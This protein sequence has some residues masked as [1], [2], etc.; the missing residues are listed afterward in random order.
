MKKNRVRKALLA[1]ICLIALFFA[2]DLVFPFKPNIHYATQIT[3]RE[4]R[5]IHAFLSREDKWRLYSN[6]DEIT[7]LLR[8]TL[9]YKEDQYFY[10]HPG[11]NP[12]AVVR[13]A[14]RNVFSGKRTSGASTITMQVVRL[15][16]PRPRTY[17]NKFIEMWHA[18][19]LEMHYS[20]AEIL[21]FYINL[22]PYGGNIEGIKAASLLYFGK[23]P[24][25]LSL[26]EITALTIVP[27]RPSGLRPGTRND[28]LREA[29]NS[30]LKR[31]QEDG[32]FDT[33]VIRDALAEPLNIRRLQTPRLAPHLSIRLKQQFPDEPV[34]R[35]HV[36]MQAQS[37]IEEQ[38]K[39]YINRRQLMNIHNA[40]VLVVNNETMEVEA[41]VGSADF[42]N[43]FD[44]GQVD[45][46]RAVRSPGSTLKPL[47]Y[48]A[49]F[50]AG[51]ITPKSV[52]NDVPGNFSGYEPENFDK[53]F[54]GAVTTE[55]ALANSLNIPAVKV[56]K[57][58]G[59][60]ALIAKLRKARF[61]TVDKQAKNLGLSMILG[62]CGVTL[63]ELTRLFAAFANEGKLRNLR[64]SGADVQ[65]KNGTTF[66]SEEATFLTTGILTQITRPDLPTNFD[67]TY[68]LPRI[69]WKTGTSYGKRDA[70]SIGYNRRYT[71]G[72]W[73]GNFSGEGVP[74]LSGANTATPL[75][76]SIFNAL[77]YNSPKGWYKTPANIS[78]RNVCPVSGDI[79]SDFCDH[80]VPDQYILG[81]SAYHKCQHMRWV[82]TDAKGKMSYCTYCLPESGFEKKAYPN[83]APELIAFYEMQKLP[84]PKIPPHN[85]LCERV[86][87]E[88]A[89]LIVSPNDGSEYYIRKDEPQQIQLACQAAND[90]QEVYWYINDK[91]FQ[92]SSPQESIF[93]TPPLGRV[94]VSCSDDKGRN[95]DVWIVVKRM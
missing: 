12:F 5:V 59:T 56:L 29:R 13:A 28:A 84:Y 9:I 16:D 67:N 42:N 44:G 61:K 45:G 52:L 21:Q 63:E 77:D 70:W 20:K 27:N 94:K 33:P 74:E 75:L 83:L 62:G 72:V 69:A 40:A 87:H 2:L 37:Q 90:V 54:N 85:P 24:Q 49:A 38:V 76:F 51:M 25:L 68:H 3:D 46:V 80:Q 26:A 39:N 53:H 82:F 60:P 57:E 6:V 95:A 86:F 93:L 88:G 66:L 81:V 65:D 58:I 89:P 8:K 10:Y 35:T 11:V 4:G 31:F 50:D 7:P 34:I 30:W 23:A 79:P 64:L 22:V 48:A 78:T 1:L 19:Q 41:Y 92:K 43:P 18:V 15:M 47:L 36:N 91:L 73:V 71:V 55:F 32:L 17:L 14:A